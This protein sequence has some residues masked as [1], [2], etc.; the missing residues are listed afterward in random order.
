MLAVNETRTIISYYLDRTL[1]C[2]LRSAGCLIILQAKFKEQDTQNIYL[3]PFMM[4]M[5]GAI[6]AVVYALG[7]E[8]DLEQWKLGW[9]IRFWASSFVVTPFALAT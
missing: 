6:Q 9:N 5:M 3:I 7:V 2:M 8:R 1:I 4:N